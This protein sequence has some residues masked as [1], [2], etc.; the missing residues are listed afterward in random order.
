MSDL[1]KDIICSIMNRVDKIL[2]QIQDIDL[3][4]LYIERDV[5]IDDTFDLILAQQEYIAIWVNKL[6]NEIILRM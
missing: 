5:D 4:S 2:P 6:A 1:K 3:L